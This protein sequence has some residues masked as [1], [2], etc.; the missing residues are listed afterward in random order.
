MADAQ[1]IQLQPPKL[2]QKGAAS[3]K[4][5]GLMTVATAVSIAGA[6]Y[7]T[8]SGK[9]DTAD[10]VL[11]SP[12]LIIAGATGATV[13]LVLLADFGG[14]PGEAWGSGLAL[15]VLLVS[16]LIQAGPLWKKL[17]TAFQT[18]APSATPTHTPATHVLKSSGNKSAKKAS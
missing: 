15:L 18:T 2:V 13:I 3:A 6:E 8:V 11:S 10:K 14:D 5:V 1:V 7:R 9:T 12:F 17:S 16:V 4:I